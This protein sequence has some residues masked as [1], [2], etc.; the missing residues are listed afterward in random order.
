MAN[1]N[2]V[3]DNNTNPY[4]YASALIPIFTNYGNKWDTKYEKAKQEQLDRLALKQLI[5]QEEDEK[6][7][8]LYS[9]YD[10]KFNDFFDSFNRGYDSNT[11]RLGLEANKLYKE[12]I[13]PIEREMVKREKKQEAQRAFKEAH[14]EVMYDVDFRDVK[15]SEMLENPN[16]DYKTYDGSIIKNNIA[17]MVKSLGSAYT[18]ILNNPNTA[19]KDNTVDQYLLSGIQKGWTLN[20]IIQ[21]AFNDDNAPEAL[22]LVGENVRQQY[23]YNNLSKEVQDFIDTKIAEGY[24]LG[25]GQFDTQWLSNQNFQSEAYKAKVLEDATKKAAE[26]EKNKKYNRREALQYKFIGEDFSK[27]ADIKT[28]TEFNNTYSNIPKGGFIIKNSDGTEQVID[29]VFDFNRKIRSLEE[30]S[31]PKNAGYSVWGNT[32]K[33]LTDSAKAAAAELERLKS[34]YKD[35]ILNDEEFSDINST[36]NSALESLGISKPSQVTD[37]QNNLQYQSGS[38]LKYNILNVTDK[39]ELD[40]AQDNLRKSQYTQLS[41]IVKVLDKKSGGLDFTDEKIPED[42]LTKGTLISIDNNPIYNYDNYSEYFSSKNLTPM[43]SDYYV[44]A[45]LEYEDPSNKEKTQYT[46]VLPSKA[47]GEEFSKSLMDAQKSLEVPGETMEENLAYNVYNKY[48]EYFPFVDTHIPQND[49]PLTLEQELYNQELQR[50]YNMYNDFIYQTNTE[51]RNAIKPKN[52][53]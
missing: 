4:D 33:P 31:K 37:K 25:V 7:L 47:F 34:E 49:Q 28:L 20:E 12:S 39:D 23:D 42:L 9:Q 32:K 22:R 44:E 17:N 11:E 40:I 41:D 16:L 2:F 13:I 53:Q 52:T 5:E 29:D 26:E 30:D 35:Y 10:T 1:Y 50:Y 36:L 14:P 6:L 48:G 51:A 21:G 45:V 43:D 27:A 3:I 18:R 8:E 46:V 19:G 24:Y 38:Y 15:I